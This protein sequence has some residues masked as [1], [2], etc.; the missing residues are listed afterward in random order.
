VKYRHF[1]DLHKGLTWLAV[2]GLMAWHDAWA[3]PPAWVYLGLHGSYGLLWALK[4][5]IFPDRSWERP[6]G[7]FYGVFVIWGALTL[8]WLPAWLVTAR[9]APLPLWLPAA[10]IAL[11]A[12]GVFLH[13]AADMQKHT[14]L[15]TAPGYL[16]SDGLFARVRN[17]NY[18]GELLIYL[19]FAL[20]ARHW[21]ALLPL[22]LFIPFHWIPNMLRKDRSLSRYPDFAEY[23][24]RTR[25]FI[26]FLF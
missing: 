4:S 2:L 22:G 9:Q 16:I 10:C 26:P 17:P 21:L 5:R 13:F 25:L 24:R 23:R 12:A 1:I 14:R 7:L 19:S 11:Y 15:N 6:A 20:L 8:Y 18:F 3:Y